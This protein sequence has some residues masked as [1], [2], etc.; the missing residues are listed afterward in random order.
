[1][2]RLVEVCGSSRMLLG[3]CWGFCQKSWGLAH[4]SSSSE[5]KYRGALGASLIVC[6][7]VCKLSS[8]K[9]ASFR[10]IRYVRVYV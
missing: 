5:R 9:G 8:H 10:R 4:M 6:A 3:G 1:V 7:H 2:I